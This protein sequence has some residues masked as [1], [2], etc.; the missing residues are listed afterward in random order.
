[1]SKDLFF[2]DTA[3]AGLLNGVNKLADAVKVTLGPCGRNVILSRPWGEPL[4]T[5][6][7]VTVAKHIDLEDKVEDLGAKLIKQASSKTNDLAGDGTTTS[8]ILAQAIIKEGVK[9]LAAGVNPIAIK[10]SLEAQTKDL[11]AKIKE[12]STPVNTPEQLKQIA[13]ISANDSEIGQIISDAM[14]SVGKEGIITVE[15]GTTFGVVKEVVIGMQFERGYISPYMVTDTATMNSEIKTPLIL[16]TDRTI[17]S[18]QEIVPLLEK[19]MQRGVKEMVIIAED[20][21]G[22]ALSTIVV[23]T[24]RGNFTVL[25]VKAPGF[26]DAKEESLLDIAAVTGGVLISAKTGRTLESVEVEELGRADLV[27]STRDNTLIVGGKGKEEDIQTRVQIAKAQIEKE[28]GEYAKGKL[29]E[30]MAK[31]TGGIA[32][33]K[34]GAATEF[35]MKEKKDRIEDA[36][37]ATKAAAEEG[38]L[39]GG[40]TALYLAS[41]SLG[42]DYEYGD[43]LKKAV[44]APIKQ[45][46]ENAGVD[47]SFVLYNIVDQNK[48]GGPVIGYNAAEDTYPQ[49]VE[50]GIIDSTKVVRCAVENAVSAAMMFLT[51]EAVISEVPGKKEEY[52][53]PQG[54]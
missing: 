24:M 6:D 17:S 11:I 2:G 1:M 39:P 22:D 14:E 33:I 13:S 54:M 45:I 26:G 36:L 25:G 31:L 10:K 37:N 27:K 53:M 4:V 30:R 40:G 7:G 48:N 18:V 5:K 21:T 23:N 28:E 29:R 34:V 43:I 49:M 20:I 32:V 16:I 52:P 3:R 38:F 42:G 15:E 8:T 46:A 35:E 41:H 12:M 47:G 19:I 9:L 50:S 44:M 51:I